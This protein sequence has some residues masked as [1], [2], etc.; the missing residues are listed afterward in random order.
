MKKAVISTKKVSEILNRFNYHP[1]PVMFQISGEH[2]WMPM[3]EPI[4]LELP[5]KCIRMGELV[6]VR[7]ENQLVKLIKSKL[8]K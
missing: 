7:T 1:N 3:N 6:S 5:S 8:N 2:I 4:D